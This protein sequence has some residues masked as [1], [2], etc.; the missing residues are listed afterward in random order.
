MKKQ[1]LL[2]RR[3]AKLEAMPLI[4][5]EQIKMIEWS[6]LNKDEALGR[7]MG[8]E[9]MKGAV[10]GM[11]KVIFEANKLIMLNNAKKDLNEALSRIDTKEYAAKRHQVRRKN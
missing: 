1:E 10:D 7:L 2:K 6:M 3:I 11:K 5:E 4:S 9:I 8:P